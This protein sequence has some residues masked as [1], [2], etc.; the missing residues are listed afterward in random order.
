MSITPRK[1][2][3]A[4][5]VGCLVMIVGWLIIVFHNEILSFSENASASHGFGVSAPRYR[6]LE[7]IGIAPIVVPK[8]K[9]R[10]V[11]RHIFA[12]DLMERADDTALEDRPKALNRL[13]CEPHRR[14][15][16]VPDSRH[17]E[18]QSDEA[19]HASLYIAGRWIASLRSQ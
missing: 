4:L 3:S 12:T 9:F 19:I 18:G 7:N 5:L 14:H 2:F 16:Q 8:L 13:M 15:I 11:H 10:D 1:G 6:S 17:C